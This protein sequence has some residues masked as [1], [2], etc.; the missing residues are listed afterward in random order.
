MIRGINQQNIFS[1][2]EDYKKFIAI[3]EIRHLVLGK[4]HIELA[5]LQ[6]APT[7]IKDKILKY[8]KELDGCSLRQVSRLTG[9]TVNKIFKV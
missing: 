5:T 8:L 4:Y 1:L 2:Y 6:S 9:F 7:I 3:K